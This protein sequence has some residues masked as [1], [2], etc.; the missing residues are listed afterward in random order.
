MTDGELEFQHIYDAFRP[1]IHDYLARLTGADEADD[2]TQ[3]V[4]IKVSRGLKGF[5]GESKLSS[6]IYRIATNAAL[7]HLRRPSQ[8]TTEM[9][10]VDTEREEE[11]VRLRGKVSFIDQQ[12]I[13]KEMNACIR[14]VIKKLPADYRTVIV[15]GELEEFKNHEIAEILQVSLDTVKIRLHRARKKLKKEL[16]NLCC[17]YRDERN[18]LSCDLKSAIRQLKESD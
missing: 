2:L 6:W 4:F 5:R 9:S 3:E 7:D 16:E 10:S 14:N 8:M 12:L 11:P 17:F 13:R 1:K 18:V 15:L